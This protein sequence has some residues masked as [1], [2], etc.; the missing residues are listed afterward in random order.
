[1]LSQATTLRKNLGDS[2]CRLE[3]SAQGALGSRLMFE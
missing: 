2:T 3:G 1:M